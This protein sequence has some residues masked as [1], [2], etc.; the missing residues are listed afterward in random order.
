MKTD[1]VERMIEKCDFYYD[2]MLISSE[3]IIN[4]YL[5]HFQSIFQ[6]GEKSTNYVL[7]TGSIAYDIASLAGL[8]F[9]GFSLEHSSNDELLESL[10]IGDKVIYENKRWLWDGIEFNEYKHGSGTYFYLKSEDKNGTRLGALYEQNKHKVKP[11]YGE[12]N[13]TDGRGIRK[14]KSNRAEFLS[15]LM[16]IPISEVPSVL[17]LSFIVLSDKNHFQDLCQNL[18]FGYGK[19]KRIKLTD[20][21]PVS[22]FTMSGEDRIGKNPAQIEAVIKGVSKTSAARKLVLNKALNTNVAFLSLDAKSINTNSS[23]LNDIIRRKSI[24]HSIITAPDSPEFVESIIENQGNPTLFICSPKYLA[25]IN[26]EINALNSITKKL[27]IEIEN[28]I[29]RRMT[30]VEVK[31]EIDEDQYF[32]IRKELKRINDSNWNSDKKDQFVITAYSLLKVY[33]TAFVSMTD[34]EDFMLS[35]QSNT[36]NTTPAEK[37]SILKEIADNHSEYKTELNPIIA[38]LEDIH[39]HLKDNSP[40]GEQLNLV[41]KE[42]KDKKIV[43]LVPQTFYVNLFNNIANTNWSKYDITCLTPN[44]FENDKICD[45]IVTCSDIKTNQFDILNSNAAPEFQLL[46]YNHE[47]KNFE[48]RKKKINKNYNKILK[49]FNDTTDSID[50]NSDQFYVNNQV[51]DDIEITKDLDLFIEKREYNAMKETYFLRES[52]G[53][54]QVDFIGKFT[55]GEVIFFSKYYKAV[56]FDGIANKVIEKD[57]KDIKPSDILVFTKRDNYR[58]NIVDL[59]FEQ[60]LSKNRLDIQQKE[61][62]EMSQYWKKALASYKQKTRYSY[63]DLAAE[64]KGRGSSIESATIR[65]W[66]DEE[67]YIIGPRKVN[68]MNIIAKMTRDSKLLSNPKS[69]SEACDTVRQLRRKILKFIGESITHKL[70]NRVPEK[71]SML[72]VVY[73][74]VENLSIELEIDSIEVLK[75]TQN[76]ATSVVNKPMEIQI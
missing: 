38:M 58:R 20:I 2:E 18:N 64:F 35:D 43:F 17:D 10:E 27:N 57:P 37:L 13:T 63:T 48:Y 32:K 74:H 54:S 26:T 53:T 42:H 46:L 75:K 25:N 23:E 50:E 1:A 8:I 22:Y 15:Y 36:S 3:T 66:L 56:I 65:A 31:A 73:E 45:L 41:F 72:E 9:A 14:S 61:A 40:K 62:Y 29:N 6:E 67:S 4:N 52:N 19:K 34:L 5:K 39:T 51:I 49:L 16:D 21:V 30:V 70:S 7:H 69:Y 68:T 28:T 33:N 60:L 76:V 44:Q 59:I 55:N 11:Y 47:H 71:G 24:Q 12:S